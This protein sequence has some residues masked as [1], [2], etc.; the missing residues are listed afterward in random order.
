VNFPKLIAAI[1]FT[2]CMLLLSA[3]MALIPAMAASL[4]ITRNEPDKSGLPFFESSDFTPVWHADATTISR[5]ASQFPAF[6]LVDQSGRSFSQADLKG[7]IVIANFFFTQCSSICP[8]L[9]TAMATV[10]DAYHNK[11]GS[12]AKVMLLSHSVTPEYD[13]APMLAAYARKNNIDGQQWRLLTGTNTQMKKVAHEGYKVP[14]T[15]VDDKGF[16]HTELFVLLDSNQRVRGVYNGTLRLEIEQ[17][18][19]DVK[20]LLTNQAQH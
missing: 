12:D 15:S 7:R 8:S 14:R 10:R 1:I 16:I 4:P 11:S 2:I 13:S 5:P 17:L 9:T 18:V 19:G 3:A 20:A 6:S